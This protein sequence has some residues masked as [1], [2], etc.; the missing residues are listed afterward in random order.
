MVSEM[1]E[2]HDATFVPPSDLVAERSVLCSVLIGYGDC[3]EIVTQILNDEDFYL[4]PHQILF[5]AMK[6]IADKGL[7]ISPET[8]HDQLCKMETDRSGDEWLQLMLQLMD[9]VPHDGHAAYHAGK[10]RH[11]SIR[12]KAIYSAMD[13]T[14]L[15]SDV[16]TDTDDLLQLIDSQLS[17]LVESTAKKAG[18]TFKTIALNAMD[19]LTSPREEGIK[20][21]YTDLDD[22]MLGAKPGQVTVIAGRPGSGKSAFVLNIVR[23][24]ARYQGVLFCSIEMPEDELLD[25][26]LVSDMKCSLAEL[27]PL[28]RNDDSREAV[29]EALAALSELPVTIDDSADQTLASIA[30]QARLARR[31]HGLGL[32][33]VD[34]MQ[35]IRSDRAK[36]SREQQVA[37][38]S[39]GLK[40]IA[41][42]LN[43]PVIALA[44]LNRELEKRPDKTPRLSDL[45]ESGAI[46]QNANVVLLIDRPGTWNDEHE[47]TEAIVYVAK[48]RGGR[49]GKIDLYWDGPSATFREPE[50]L[51]AGF[52]ANDYPMDDPSVDFGP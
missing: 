12:R 6:L 9:T 40:R 14:R 15:A 41:K 34:Y 47:E 22:M 20:L 3:L 51:A 28:A 10:V 17:K 18:K 32:I 48:N 8:L 11:A 16:N 49:T 29:L 31:T 21:G 36:D 25:R 30:Q 24:V 38:I 2:S 46:E 13:I 4:A 27:R 23:K 50:S 52:H 19:R 5:C 45:R 39:W 7:P 35:I 1:S 37:A 33:V 44:Q 42:Q 43:V 26:A